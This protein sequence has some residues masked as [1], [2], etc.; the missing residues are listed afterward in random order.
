MKQILL[1]GA[2]GKLG[3]VITESLLAHKYVVVA[4]VRNPQKL[5]I[6]NENLLVYKGDVTNTND[7][8]NAL[9]NTE[10]VI[11]TLGHGFRTANP[12]QEK[13]L[14]TLLPLMQKNSVKRFITVTGAAL[15]CNGDP[16][17]FTATI[18]EQLLTIIDPYRMKDAQKQQKLLEE[19][20]LDWTVI[21]TPINN[22]RSNQT[23]AHVGL[24]QPYPWQTISRKAIADFMLACIEQKTWIRQCPII[25]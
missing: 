5:K 12:I 14:V 21:R 20:S 18:T 19:C 11:S 23:I 13:T 8:E 24:S 7:I 1:L 22:N 10:V 16:N 4:L 3:T 15:V 9:K 17:S 25:Y 6:S 2:T